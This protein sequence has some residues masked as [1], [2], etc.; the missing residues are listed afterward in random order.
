MRRQDVQPG[1]VYAYREGTYGSYRKAVVLTPVLKDTLYTTHRWKNDQGFVRDIYRT[2]P[3]QYNG[4]TPSSGWLMAIG[5]DPTGASLQEALEVG[6][7]VIDGEPLDWDKS[8]YHY[9][10]ITSMAHLHGDYEQL[11]RAEQEADEARAD[12]ARQRAEKNKVTSAEFLPLRDILRR[13]IDGTINLM[14]GGSLWEPNFSRPGI[15]APTHLT[16]DREA[17]EQLVSLLSAQE[18]LIHGLRAEY[19]AVANENDDLRGQLP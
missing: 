17:A 18:E 14:S 4:Y 6:K 1:K 3:A 15:S 9:K 7:Q 13:K 16:F 2:S 12:Q 8:D 10:L 5:T 11:T 19:Q